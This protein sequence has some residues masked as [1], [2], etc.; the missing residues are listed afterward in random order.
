MFPYG[1]SWKRHRRAFW[2][3]FRPPAIVNYQSTQ[4]AVTAKLLGKLLERPLDFKD[5][6][7]L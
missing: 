2:E 7:R 4:K 3:H 1:S 5:H 6:I